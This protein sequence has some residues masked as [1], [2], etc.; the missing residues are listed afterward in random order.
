MFATFNSSLGA[1]E[2]WHFMYAFGYLLE[3][4]VYLFTL[5]LEVG[6]TPL[7]IIVRDRRELT[8]SEGQ[9]LPCGGPPRALEKSGTVEK[10][11]Q[12]AGKSFRPL[13]DYTPKFLCP[14]L[15]PGRPLEGG[16]FAAPSREDREETP[17]MTLWKEEGITEPKGSPLFGGSALSFGGSAPSCRGRPK[18]YSGGSEMKK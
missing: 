16:C 18:G 4:P 10:W 11:G 13:N 17:R 5:D 12:S 6:D 8:L 3:H 1:V 15:P 9:P 2:W 14:L 7:S